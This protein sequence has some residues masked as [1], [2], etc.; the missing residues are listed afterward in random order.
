MNY[1][2][3]NNVHVKK[4]SF[5]EYLLYTRPMLGTLHRLFNLI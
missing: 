2:N 4:F 5:L 3:N 1:K